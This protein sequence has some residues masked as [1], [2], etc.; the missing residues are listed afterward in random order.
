MEIRSVGDGGCGLGVCVCGV[1]GGGGGQSQ[2]WKKKI[3]DFWKIGR[4]VGFF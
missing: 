1:E 2:S 3:L 4:L